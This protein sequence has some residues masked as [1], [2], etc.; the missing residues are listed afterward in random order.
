MPLRIASRPAW[1]SGPAL[2]ELRASD[3]DRER[4]ANLLRS[5]AGDGRL[6]VEELEERLDEAYRAT[7]RKVL[8]RL[9][10]DVLMEAGDF[11]PEP[12][13]T[14][15]S[16]GT[17]RVVSVLGGADRSGRWR[18]APACRV[19]NVLGGVDLDL[20]EIEL[21]AETTELR[22]FSLLG[23][24]DISLPENLNVE[25]SEFSF[26][27]GN[28]LN[29][30]EAMPDPGGPVLRLRMVSILGGSEVR[31]GAKVALADRWTAR[32]QQRRGKRT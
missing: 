31:R 15:G 22:V 11:L 12:V 23:G 16:L 18:L 6:T 32:R 28:D 5:A 21:S 27:G 29:V 4:A 26:L 10:D 13:R 8:E 17:E 25:V 1:F 3:A 24:S 2:T 19:T 20:T 30:G 7:T 14:D 9:V